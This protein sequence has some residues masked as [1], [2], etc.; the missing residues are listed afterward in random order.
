MSH[1]FTVVLVP[2]DTE[3]IEEKVS[4]LLAPYNENREVE[5]YETDCW[6][7]GLKAR[8]ESREIADEKYRPL[9]EIRKEFWTDE[10]IKKALENPDIFKVTDKEWENFPTRLE[11]EH[12]RE[13]A[14]KDHLLYQKPNPECQNCGGTGKYITTYNPRAK[15]DWWV[16]GGRYDGRVGSGSANPNIAPVSVL[17]EKDVMPFAVVTPNG[18][19]HERGKMG[20]FGM[21]FDN[22]EENDWTEKVRSIFEKHRDCLAVGCDLHI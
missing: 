1:F 7:I 4:E 19:W 18:K 12:V 16:I 22:K 3:N 21:S 13:Q 8:Q 20:W 5:P 10:R 14:E 11:W 17:L 15:W 2:A 6:C 9:D